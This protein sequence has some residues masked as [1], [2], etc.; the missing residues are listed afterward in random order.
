M[1]L[2]LYLV[3]SSNNVLL[4]KVAAKAAM[5]WTVQEKKR[6]TLIKV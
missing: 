1:K 4:T 2:A 6:K 3:Q 5:Y